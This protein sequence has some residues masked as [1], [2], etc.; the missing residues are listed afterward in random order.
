MRR[1]AVTVVHYGV[2]A[3]Q[4]QRVGCS[5]CLRVRTEGRNRLRVACQLVMDEQIG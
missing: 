3:G 4:K 1:S 5:G 2:G